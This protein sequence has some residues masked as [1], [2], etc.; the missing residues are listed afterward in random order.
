MRRVNFLGR[1]SHRFGTFRG[2][3]KN[4]VQMEGCCAENQPKNGTR[5]K[6]LL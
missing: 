2:A 1:A 3:V 6:E 5:P 4:E